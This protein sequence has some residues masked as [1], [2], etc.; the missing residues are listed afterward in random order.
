MCL[1]FFALNEHPTYKLIIAANRDEFYERATQRA[2]WWQ[3]NKSILGGKD[4][5][6]GGTWM[7]ITLQGKIA[8]V[9]NYRDLANLKTKAPSRGE[10]VSSFLTDDKTAH[11]FLESRKDT[12]QTY[13]GF[14][15]VAG[16]VN[17][18]WYCSNYKTGIE[19]LDKG[20]FGLSNALLDTPWPKVNLGKEEFKK[21]IEAK[22]PSV[23]EL[24]RVLQNETQASDNLLPHT[25]VGIARERVL[26][27]RF[28][29]SPGYGTRCS[30][31][32]LINKHNEVH[33]IERTYNLQTFAYEE[34]IHDFEIKELPV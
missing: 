15:L 5:E 22:S 1:I 33:F 11:Q 23:N 8:F 13:N 32:I 20:V 6:A 25:G 24:F 29:K 28:I 26:S 31:V 27:A 16:T 9:T 3:E 7:A 12:F 17:Q 21:A 10:L 30:T 19:K 18:L 34:V 2:S 4:I 14:N